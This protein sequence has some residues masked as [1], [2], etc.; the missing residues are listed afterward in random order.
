MSNTT[1][2][3]QAWRSIGNGIGYV[4]AINNTGT[5]DKYSYTDKADKALLM[6]ENQCKAFCSYMQQCAT[7]GFW[8]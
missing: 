2:I 1:H 7:V 6:T 4:E 8:S 5:G 3:H